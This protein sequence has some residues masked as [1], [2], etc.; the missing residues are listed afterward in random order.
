MAKLQLIEL[1]AKIKKF[2]FCSSIYL[3]S[4]KQPVLSK[5]KEKKK[6]YEKKKLTNLMNQINL[7]K[8]LEQMKS[9]KMKD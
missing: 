9:K 3:N 4:R 7:K 5:Q 1:N 2:H 6:T 8:R